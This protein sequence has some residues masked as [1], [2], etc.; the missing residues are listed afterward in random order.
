VSEETVPDNDY[1][2]L[3]A[4]IQALREPAREIMIRRFFHG[5][6]PQKIADCMQL[7]KKQVENYLYNAKKTISDTLTRTEEGIQ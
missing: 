4:A 5:Q 6:K 3:Y 7:P 2:A 1:Q